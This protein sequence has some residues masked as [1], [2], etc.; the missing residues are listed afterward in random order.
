MKSENENNGKNPKKQDQ[1]MS[2]ENG[3]G[4]KVAKGHRV[5][6]VIVPEKVFNHAK[7]QAFLSEISWT[8]FISETLRQCKPITPEPPLEEN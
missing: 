3:A 1:T 6:H 5:V 8:T 7:A 2:K 4:R